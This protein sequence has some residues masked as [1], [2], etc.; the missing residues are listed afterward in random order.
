[1]DV[2]GGTI[3]ITANDDGL[4]AADGSDSTYTDPFGGGNDSCVITISGGVLNIDAGGDGLDSNGSLY[5][6]GGEVY[7]SGST[8]DG[9][10][11][12]DY[13]GSASVTGGIVVAAGMRGMAQSFGADST[14]G[15]I[16]LSFGQ[17]T[18]EPITLQDSDGTVLAS[19]TPP[20]AYDSVAVS[21][22]GLT[23]GSTYTVTACGESTEVTLDSLI[24][25]GGMGGMGF[26]GMGGMTPPD[27]TEAPDG[28]T[29]P[30]GTELPDGMTPPDGSTDGSDSPEPPSGGFPGGNGGTPPA[31][32]Q[33]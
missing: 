24:Y 5:V 2:S 22:P 26:G 10:S 11:A 23:T 17:S 18:T 27:G 9:D 3:D 19:Y 25:G 21:A 28:M 15:S 32:P 1:M 31:K 8:G 7:V 14:Q 30:D 29:P 6:T 33:N 13:N 16:L 4:N 20:K 12:L